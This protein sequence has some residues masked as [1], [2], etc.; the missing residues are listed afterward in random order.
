[1]P[2]EL[3]S[4]L[5]EQAFRFA[6]AHHAGQ[7]RRGSNLPYT[8]HLSA[9]ALIL[10][11]LGFDEPTL[12]A[13]LLHDVVEDTS[14]T[15]AEVAI[16]FGPQVADTVRHCSELKLDSQGS[17]RPW[18]DRKR[19]H[20]GAIPSAPLSARAIILADKLHNLITIELDL[21]HSKPIWSLFH[22]PRDQ[23]L[24]YYHAAIT[25]CGQDD[26]R[27]I[28]LATNC[29]AILSRIEAKPPVIPA[30]THAPHNPP[31]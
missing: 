9:V 30:P 17:K 2:P 13:A 19:D 1:M 27:L 20:I 31:T 8:A 23:V 10:A 7:T 18:I 5:L 11:R 16:E 3:F 15:L 28:A 24:W 21:T 29:F 6:D 25:A 14:A 22:A 26:P 12:A 4:H